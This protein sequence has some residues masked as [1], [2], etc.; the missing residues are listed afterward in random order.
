MFGI[1]NINIIF[2]GLFFMSLDS[3]N[4]QLVVRAPVIPDHH[5]IGGIRGQRLEMT[6]FDIKQL[7]DFGLIGKADAQGKPLPGSIDDVDGSIMQFSR[8]ETDVGDFTTDKTKFKG[9]ITLP[10]PQKF[11]SVRT[12]Y[13]AKFRYVQGARYKVGDKIVANA[14]RK[15]KSKV[16]VVALLQYSLAATQTIDW[17]SQLNIHFYLQPCTDHKI[18]DV[19]NDLAAAANCFTV[20]AGFDLLMIDDGQEPTPAQANGDLVLGTSAEDEQSVNEEYEDSPDIQ[21]ICPAP[22]APSPTPPAPASTDAL[23]QPAVSPAN[24]PI[25]FVG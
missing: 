15:R 10:W 2:H 19:N 11:I 1:N 22:P 13:I 24:C 3:S 6:D 5:F 18:K 14:K 20:P 12:D 23:P 25:F 8:S 7:L 21:L 4:N 17:A 9:I 16:G